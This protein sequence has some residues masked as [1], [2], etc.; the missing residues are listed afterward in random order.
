MFNNEFVKSIWIESENKGSIIEDVDGLDDNSDVIVHFENVTSYVATFFTYKNLLSL[1]EKNKKSRECLSGNY[2][3]A[4]EMII[5]ER[6]ERD[7]I[8]KVV[9]EFLNTK[10]FYDA[11]KSIENID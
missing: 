4:S 8:E 3:W 10:C 1:R 6:I 5:V 9:Q 2:F 7:L 11:F